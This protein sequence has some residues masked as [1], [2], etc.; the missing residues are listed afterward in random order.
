MIASSWPWSR[1]HSDASGASRPKL[2][3]QQALA[4]HRTANRRS[5]SLGAAMPLPFAGL[6]RPPA[7]LLALGVRRPRRPPF[8]QEV[9]EQGG[10]VWPAED[11]RAVGLQL[12]PDLIAQ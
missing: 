7:R 11:A 2:K 10:D 4:A 3:A 5:D 8:L 1:S 9:F 12:G 6:R